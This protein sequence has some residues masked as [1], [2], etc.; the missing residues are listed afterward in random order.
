MFGLNKQ[1]AKT[2][3]DCINIKIGTAYGKPVC[4]ELQLIEGRPAATSVSL[5][6]RRAE[7]CH[8]FI[9]GRRNVTPPSVPV[10]GRR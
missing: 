6:D 7:N 3:G 5:T 1:L 2:C 10:A 4:Y 8:K 9:G